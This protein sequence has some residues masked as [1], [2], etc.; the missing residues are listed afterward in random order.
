MPYS[1]IYTRDDAASPWAPQFGDRD[2]DA[3]TQERA[4]TY[5]RQRGQGF[6]GDCKHAAADI[7]IVRFPRVPTEPQVAAKTAELNA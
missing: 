5:L 2:H 6:P 3:V 7:K 4:D 1:M